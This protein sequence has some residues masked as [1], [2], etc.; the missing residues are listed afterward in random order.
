MASMCAFGPPL[1]YRALVCRPMETEFSSFGTLLQPHYRGIPLVSCS[2]TIFT[3]FRSF[4][5]ASDTIAEW[6]SY[7]STHSMCQ[8]RAYKSTSHISPPSPPAPQI[9]SLRPFLT[10]VFIV[11]TDIQIGIAFGLIGVVLSLIGLYISYL[12]L[13]ATIDE[14]RSY[15][16]HSLLSAIMEVRA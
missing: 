15:S 13:R 1:I 11:S 12:T 3:S 7:Y 16:D 5:Q 10:Q 8:Y 4:Q 9:P 14:Q 2:P 6:V